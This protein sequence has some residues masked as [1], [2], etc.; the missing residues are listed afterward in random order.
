LVL[1]EM[2]LMGVGSGKADRFNE[3]KNEPP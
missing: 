1:I 2:L 3:R